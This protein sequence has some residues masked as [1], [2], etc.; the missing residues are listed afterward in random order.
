MIELA[1]ILV[2][3]ILS[4]WFAWRAKI[5]SIVPLILTG[6]LVGP[7][8]EFFSPGGSKFIDGDKLFQGH[9]LFDFIS[10]SVGLILFEGGLTLKIGEVKHLTKVIRNLIIVGGVVTLLGGAISAVLFVGFSWKLAFLFGSLI[11]VTGPTVIGPILRNVRAKTNVATILKW[12]GILI[13]PIG[14]LTAILVFDYVITL[15]DRGSYINILGDFGL[16][17]LIGLIIGFAFAE[18]IGILLK[19]NYI[20]NYLKNVVVLSLVILS[21]T[22]SDRLQSESG[23][24]AVTIMGIVLGNKKI[25]D[26]EDI[27]SFKADIVT[28]LMSIL[29]IILSSRI[30]LV[31]IQALGWESL[32]VPASII[33]VIRPLGVF[34]S[35]NKSLAL[36]EKLFIAWIGPRGIVAAGVAS[37]FALRLEELQLDYFDPEIVRR[38][39]PLTFLVI[40]STVIVQGFSARAMARLLGVHHPKA[41]GIVFLG[42]NEATRMMAKLIQSLG[43]NVMLSDINK[44]SLKE[45]TRMGLPVYYP[46]ILGEFGLDEMDFSKFGQLWAI[47]PNTE[48]NF[49]ALQTLEDDFGEEKTF[50]I[51]SRL[52]S[53]VSEEELPENL[54]FNGEVDFYKLVD[55]CRKNKEI[56]EIKIDSKEHYKMLLEDREYSRIPLFLLN[57]EKKVWPVTGALKKV[58]KGD[59]LFY[60]TK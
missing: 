47:T 23:L 9:L 35:T 17:I 44:S 28:I 12:E 33:F 26:M 38:I 3:G 15:A 48:V 43:V 20:P 39:L 32:W 40:L 18:M 21:F 14:A 5:P 50:R 31:D 8:W 53:G 45:A 27:L 54:L 1:G 52:E 46:N 30:D 41:Y 10:L 58:E 29:F 42:A 24:L 59:R 4:Q 37:V 22:I 19:K 11:I 7:F 56:R 51:R 36:N 6:L 60:F 57:D 49:H 16:K 55:L 13:D 34:L 25:R 2:L